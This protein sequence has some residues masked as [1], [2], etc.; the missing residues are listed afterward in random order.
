MNNIFHHITTY[1]FEKR[2]HAVPAGGIVNVRFG[3]SLHDD[4]IAEAYLTHTLYPTFL[5][6]ASTESV[7]VGRI[8]EEAVLRSDLHSG[9]DGSFNF[10]SENGGDQNFFIDPTSN[11]IYGPTAIEAWHT[12]ENLVGPANANG[13]EVFVPWVNHSTLVFITKLKR[14]VNRKVDGSGILSSEGYQRRSTKI[15]RN[16]NGKSSLLNKSGIVP[17]VTH[18]VRRSVD[19]NH[20]F[21]P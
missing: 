14:F 21:S 2:I 13:K 19:F 18:V 7:S 10:I 17:L 9:A 16:R 11:I 12:S 6:G 5:E 8:T 4:S 20:A 3:S 1:L 15:N